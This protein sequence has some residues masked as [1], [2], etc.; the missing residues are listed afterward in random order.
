LLDDDLFLWS[1]LCFR[2]SHIS[3]LKF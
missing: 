2:F 3:Y 1:V